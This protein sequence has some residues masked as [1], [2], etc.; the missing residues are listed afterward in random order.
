MTERVLS[1]AL[2]RV[3]SG[4][5]VAVATVLSAEG[6][7]PGKPGARM[8]IDGYG[9]TNGTIGGAGLEMQVTSRLEKLLAETDRNGGDVV[10]FHLNK[11]ANGFE[12][13]P[14][15]SLCGGRVTLSLE[16]INPMPH[17]LM[18]GGGHVAQALASACEVLGWAHSVQDSRAEFCNSDLFPKAR[19]LHASNANFFIDSI[20]FKELNRFTNILLLGHDWKED[21]NR[22]LHL[23]KRKQSGESGIPHIGVIGSRAKWNAFTEVALESGI[24][25]HILDQIQC[26]IGLNIG[27][28]SPE[29][30]A[31]AVCADMIAHMK[32][33]DP[34]NPDWR[35]RLETLSD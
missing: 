7:V 4:Q 30:I 5:R 8:A 3:E 2:E 14:L 28:Q 33:V 6:S 17:I 20:E 34:Q 18:M 1:W 22:L 10:T 11:G 35:A 19:E 24:S 16:L 15:D 12:V 23:M 29:E 27:A 21:Q 13:V 31:V 26:P 25:K 32:N 9:V